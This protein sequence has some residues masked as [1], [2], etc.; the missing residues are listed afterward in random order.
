[1]YKHGNTTLLPA[2]LISYYMLRHA[3]RD[4]LDSLLSSDTTYNYSS[5]TDVARGGLSS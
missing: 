1:M 5:G 2:T 3:L 4:A